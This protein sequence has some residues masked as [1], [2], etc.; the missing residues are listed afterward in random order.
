MITMIVA[1]IDIYMA[2]ISFWVLVVRIDIAPD[3]LIIIMHN[4]REKYRERATDRTV[5]GREKIL[6]SLSPHC[7]VM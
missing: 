6:H 1:V 3:I 5:E 4:R 7:E 2:V